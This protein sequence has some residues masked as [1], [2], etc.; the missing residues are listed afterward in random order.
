MIVCLQRTGIDRINIV[1]TIDMEYTGAG[2]LIEVSSYMVES[3]IIKRVMIAQSR[4]P[5]LEWGTAEGRRVSL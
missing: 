4:E 3:R 5:S 2:T 1:V